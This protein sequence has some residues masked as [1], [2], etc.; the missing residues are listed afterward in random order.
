MRASKSSTRERRRSTARPFANRSPSI[1]LR[2]RPARRS[3]CSSISPPPPT[4]R[5]RC[6]SAS[7]SAPCR[8]RSMTPAS[9]PRKPG[10]PKPIPSHPRRRPVASATLTPSFLD[11]G[12][13]VATYYYGDVDP[14]YPA[15]FPNGIR[16][17]YL[18]PGQTDRAPDDWGSIAAW[19]WGMSR[20]EDYFETDKS[21]DAKARGDPRR[22]P[23]GQ[24]RHVGRRARPAL[25]RRDRKLS[26]EGGAA[27]SHRDYG[28]TIAHLTAPDPLPLSVRRQLREVRRLP[29]Q[30]PLRRQ[31]AHRPHRSAP[32]SCRPATPITGPIPKV[33]FWPP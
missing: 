33:S 16:A 25:R 1:S 30:S 22:L 11:A 5:C 4:S 26:G 15:G 17:S 32:C 7:I 27:L 19:A 29:R 14:D 28:E 10:T 3:I 2:T 24:D 20:V 21:I 18:K 8:T 23:P 13:G 12:I 6:S 9:H 31:S